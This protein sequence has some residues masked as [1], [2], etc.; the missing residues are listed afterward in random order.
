[1]SRKADWLVPSGL[2][3]LSIVPLLGGLVRLNELAGNAKITADNA[4][5]FAAPVPVVVH[6]ATACLF[7]LLGA[8]QFSR[9]FRTR[10]P[11]WHRA[12]GRPLIAAGLISALSGLWLTLT[13]PHVAGD[14]PTLYYV[15]LVVGVAM[16]L[17][18]LFAINAIRQR[19][20]MRH[21]DFMIRA[22]ALGLGAGT[23]VFTHL[24]WIISGGMPSAM[25]RDAAMA[26]G[27]L[28]NALVAEW[29]IRKGRIPSVGL[30]ATV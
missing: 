21:G 20:F 30:N 12:A 6:I 3:F 19:N 24:P 1:M 14:G 28:I 5:F 22:Y 27:W 25:S 17:F 11:Q 26:A 23:Q 7:C 4:R 8:L 9:G 29:V 13:Y 16:T 2:I 18:I 15:R 10:K